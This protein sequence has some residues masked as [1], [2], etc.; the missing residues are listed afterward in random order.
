MAESIVIAGHSGTGKSSSIFPNKELGIK[1]L[2]S[3]TTT[4]INVSSKALPFK[5]WKKVYKE[6]KNY[7]VASTA[8]D[9]INI[10]K[11][12]SEKKLTDKVLVI[13]DAQYLM[14]FELMSRAK[15]SG[16]N[17]FTDIGVNIASVMKTVREARPDLT[18]VFIWHP[19][20]HKEDGMKLKTVGKMV[21][22]Y[23]TLEG[24]FTTIL[25]TKV[26]REDDKMIYQFVTNNDG[27]YP[28]KSPYGM[29]DK[30]YIPNDLGYV[31]DKVNEYN[32]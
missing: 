29:F 10:I 31:L 11:Y 12:I 4:L 8:K 25:Y 13:D 28:S 19:E 5:G 21:D 16:Y 1:G 7:S 26:E 14:A 3:E 24:L 15:E 23:L 6:K 20:N 22:D 27:K 9:V 2:D 17:K 30:L 32:N 18:V